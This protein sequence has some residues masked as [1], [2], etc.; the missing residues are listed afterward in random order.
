MHTQKRNTCKNMNHGKLNPPVKFC[1]TC[2][3][4]F[5]STSSEKCDEE[6][7]KALRKDRNFFCHYCGKNLN[8]M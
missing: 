1:P 7:H 6:K 2:G 8:V 5:K 3:D 4:K